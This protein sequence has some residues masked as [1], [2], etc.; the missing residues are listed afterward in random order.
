MT[1]KY[2]N[3]ANLKHNNKYGYSLVTYNKAKDIINIIC[4]KHGTFKQRADHHL[5]GSGC[6]KCVGKDKTVT[7]L[8]N[9]FKLI[10]GD[11]Y[12]YSLVE[13]KNAN[14]KIKIICPHHGNF[15]LYARQ[16]SKGVNC[17]NCER[18]RI[19]INQ[20]KTTNQFV[21]QARITHNNTYDYSLVEYTIATKPVRIICNKHGIFSQIP[22]SHIRGSGCPICKE[23][24]GERKIRQY[25]ESKNIKFISQFRF[26]DCKNLRPL[27]F[28]FYVT[29]YNLCIE[30]QGEQHYLNKSFFNNDIKLEYIKNNDITKL[31]YCINNNIKI[32]VISYKEY[33][34]IPTILQE[35]LT[36]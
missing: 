12:D 5:N 36:T 21:H 22:R 6:P 29:D 34:N 1:N 16:H 18:E 27:P 4:L 35:Y 7:E 31:N 24:K 8:I 33:K 10:H 3:K 25:L 11:K 28:D 32:C 30:Y 9:Q 23:S 13:Y 20:R 17:S 14:T 15:E 2:I 19:S 26:P